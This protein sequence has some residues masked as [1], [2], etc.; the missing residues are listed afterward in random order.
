MYA[1]PRKHGK[2]NM[3]KAVFDREAKAI[4]GVTVVEPVTRRYRAVVTR[5]IRETAVVE[6]D[7]PDGFD[8]YAIGDELM[9]MVPPD[10]WTPSDPQGGWVD[11]IE[12]VDA[13]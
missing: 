1:I 11:R 13:A 12:A 8:T 5:N 6:F 9:R 4:A 2:T 10:A 3:A 7:A